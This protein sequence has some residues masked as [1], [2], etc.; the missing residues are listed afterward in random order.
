MLAPSAWIMPGTALPQRAYR[1]RSREGSEGQPGSPALQPW[2]SLLTARAR[3]SP[4]ARCPMP[5]GPRSLQRPANGSGDSRSNEASGCYTCPTC[6]GWSMGNTLLV[7]LFLSFPF[8]TEIVED[9]G[10]LL[11]EQQKLSQATERERPQVKRPPAN[12]TNRN[13][14]QPTTPPNRSGYFLPH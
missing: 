7:T 12:P 9:A 10:G 2:S 6:Y 8:V 11:K 1:F 14:V 5:D 13:H 4:G 3:I